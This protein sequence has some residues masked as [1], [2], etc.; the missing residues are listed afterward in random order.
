LDAVWPNWGKEKLSDKKSTL[1]AGCSKVKSKC[2]IGRNGMAMVIGV[3]RLYRFLA[4]LAI[5]S[6]QTYNCPIKL[7]QFI[8]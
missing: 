3:W 2:A 5:Q 6:I 4:P 8:D 7:I 1:G